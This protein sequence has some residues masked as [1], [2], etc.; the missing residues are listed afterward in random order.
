MSFKRID[1]TNDEEAVVC[2]IVN[3]MKLI[4]T[5]NAGS[6][7]IAEIYG[8][9]DLHNVNLSQDESIRFIE[10]H[11]EL[12]LGK[13]EPRLINISVKVVRDHPAPTDLYVYIEGKL[14]MDGIGGRRIGF[15]A[16]L[17]KN[18]DVKSF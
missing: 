3:N 16:N 15:S 12:C 9:P 18:G 6:A 1:A 10:R 11:L 7:E 5:T 14:Y 8:K 13:Y 17:F 2:S 4:L